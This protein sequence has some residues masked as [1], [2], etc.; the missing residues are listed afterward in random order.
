MSKADEMFEKL[1]YKKTYNIN[2]DEVL[3]IGY[4]LNNEKIDE[5]EIIFLKKAK[6]IIIG[7]AIG[8]EELQAINEKCKELG[9]NE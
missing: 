3:M 9:W 2:N 1:G 6:K 4:G 8:M 5:C 7:I